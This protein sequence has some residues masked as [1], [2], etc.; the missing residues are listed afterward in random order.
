MWVG[1]KLCIRSIIH[2]YSMRAPKLLIL[3][4]YGP[5]LPILIAKGNIKYACTRMVTMGELCLQPLDVA[6]EC[7]SNKRHGYHPT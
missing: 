1:C 6:I 7:W 4:I 3:V 5:L 2:R